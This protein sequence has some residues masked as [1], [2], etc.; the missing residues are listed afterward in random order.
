VYAT[1]L[2]AR[3]T[4]SLAA[5]FVSALVAMPIAACADG[6]IVKPC[7]NAQDL[8]R[9]TYPLTHIANKIAAGEAITIVAIG[10]SSTAG[11]GASSAAASYPNQLADEMKRHFPKITVTMINRGI[12]GEEIADMLKRFDRDVVATKP[13]LVLWQFGTNSLIR[14]SAL[15]DRGAMVREGLTKIRSVGADAILVDPQFAP[16]VVAK[17]EAERM[18]EFMSKTAKAE[19]VDLFRRFEVMKQWT[20]GEGLQFSDFVIADGLHMND[21]GYACMAKGLGMAIVEAAQRQIVSA[22]VMRPIEFAQ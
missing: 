3:V 13:D 10:S 18:V 17:P 16:K 11:A 15:N 1:D 21:W 9:L 19:S 4:K 2:A 7:R 20:V 6:Q 5:L 12:N 8:L 14:D 22:K